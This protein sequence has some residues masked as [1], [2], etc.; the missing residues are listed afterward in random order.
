MKPHAARSVFLPGL[1]AVIPARRSQYRSC[2]SVALSH[3]A[4]PMCQTALPRPLTF[5]SNMSWQTISSC[6]AISTLYM[7]TD[8]QV[9]LTLPNASLS[10][11]GSLDS[12]TTIPLQWREQYYNIV[13]RPYL[14]SRHH[15]PNYFKE[16][17][18][19]I[20]FQLSQ[21]S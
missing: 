17:H 8:I 19:D 20:T 11:D 18:C 1:N 6:T 10:S 3:P 14:T 16:G 7:L 2:N 4:E 13:M 21:M 9:E 5:L 15:L 12:N